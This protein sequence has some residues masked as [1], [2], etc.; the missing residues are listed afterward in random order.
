[1]GIEKMQSMSCLILMGREGSP[2]QRF[3]CHK[4]V[5]E[6]LFFQGPWFQ[7]IVEPRWIIRPGV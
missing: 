7:L 5:T 2:R 4:T 1:M 6:I 3:I